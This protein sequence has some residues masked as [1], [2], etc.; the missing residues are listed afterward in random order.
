MLEEKLKKVQRDKTKISASCNQEDENSLSDVGQVPRK[1]K[2][3][4]YKI[5]GLIRMTN[6]V[7]LKTT[8]TY[9]DNQDL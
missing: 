5:F 7:N 1:K 8:D 2:Q 6:N 4:R 9:R 3:I